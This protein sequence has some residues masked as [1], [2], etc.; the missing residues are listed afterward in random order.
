MKPT[1]TGPVIEVTDTAAMLAI[2]SLEAT[3][4]GLQQTIA[5]V[6]RGEPQARVIVRGGEECLA[7]F[8]GADGYSVLRLRIDRSTGDAAIERF[9]PG[10]VQP[11]WNKTV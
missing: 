1:D 6:Q 3:L 9:L 11:V 2:G 4:S 8:I 5:I 7:S 10:S